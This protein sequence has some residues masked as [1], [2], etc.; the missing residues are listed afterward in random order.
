MASRSNKHVQSPLEPEA[1]ELIARRFRAL[2]DPT[3]LRILDHL[4]NN[5]EVSVGEITEALGAS[6]QNVSK[7]LAALH[8]E[9]F[10]TRR[11]RG[12]SSLYRIADP[13]VH[14]ICD[15]V[16]AGIESQLAELE[17]VFNS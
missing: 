4:R 12:T 17:A 10:V 5:D 2:A 9:G 14:E 13:G 3:R 6:Q 16:T 15:G 7:H 8:A 1:A 11:K